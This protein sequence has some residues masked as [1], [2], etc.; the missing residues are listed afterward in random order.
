[1]SEPVLRRDVG[2]VII[3]TLNAPQVRNAISVQ[4][5]EQLRA[6]LNDASS[7]PECRAIVLTGAEGHFCSGG[8]IQQG[9]GAETNPDPQRTR[10]NILILHDIVRILSAGPKPTV[11]AVEGYAYGAGLSLAAACD[12]LVASDAAR[13]CASFGKVG[14]MADAGLIWSLPQRVGPARARD[15]M[16]TGRV[17]EAAE[18]GAVGLANQVVPAGTALDV[19]MGVAGGFTHMA[20]LAITSMKTILAR[21]P[22]SLEE[23]LS[24]EADAQPML[25]LSQDY[26]EGR[27]AFKEKRSP[28]FRGV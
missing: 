2:E 7:S 13:F 28:V 8:Q 14:L 16:L 20:P 4:M 15:I 21:G 6:H 27:A 1:M 22:N 10:R 24:A 25:T 11:A 26:A 3:L 23:V 18:A 5:R 12:Y 9:N 17:V 19:A